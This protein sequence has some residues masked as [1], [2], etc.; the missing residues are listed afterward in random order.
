MIPPV[1]AVSAENTPRGA[2]AVRLVQTEGIWAPSGVRRSIIA[3]PGYR[4]R[5]AQ[6]LTPATDL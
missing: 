3:G 6:G 2:R 5:Q 4:P 1:N